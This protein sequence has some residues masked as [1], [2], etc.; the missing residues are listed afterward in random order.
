MCRS[1]VERRTEVQHEGGRIE[2]VST[3]DGGG[4]LRKRGS[5]LLSDAGGLLL[6]IEKH[7]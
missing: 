4:I 1:R 6:V 7:V 3:L 2:I 5:G